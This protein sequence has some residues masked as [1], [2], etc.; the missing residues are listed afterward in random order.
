MKGQTQW[1]KILETL[2][3]LGWQPQQNNESADW[4]ALQQITL[5]SGERPLI[6]TLLADP[7]N[8]SPQSIPW[9]IAFD[10]EFPESRMTAGKIALLSIG[11]GWEQ[12][13]QE[14]I[15]RLLNR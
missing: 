7:Q 12:Q 4:W 14:F 1:R 10:A 11:N 8:D 6:V 9:A 3:N 2:E 15:N 13:F 5:Q